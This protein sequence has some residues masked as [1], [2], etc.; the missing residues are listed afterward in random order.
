VTVTLRAYL[1]EP[2]RL[3]GLV[4][5]AMALAA[6][7]M[8]LYV[9][10]FR[11]GPLPTTLLE[12]FILVTAGLFALAVVRRAGRWPGRTPYE[13]PIVLF[14][15]GG[16]IGVFVAPDHRGGLGIFRAYLVEP[17]AIYYV[18]LAIFEST[19]QLLPLLLTWGIG[20]VLFCLVDLA[21][22]LQALANGSFEPGHAAAAFQINPNSIALYLEP[23]IGLAAGFLILGV[24]RQRLIALGLLAVVLP[25]EVATFSRGGLLALGILA[26]I[27]IITLQRLWLQAALIA[28]T[29]LAAYG[30]RHLPL[31]G[32]RIAQSLDPNSGTLFNRE[33]VWVA[34][35]HMLHDRPVFGAGLNAYQTVM[36]PYRAVDPNQVP[37]P[38]PHNFIFTAWTETGLLGLFAFV[39]ILAGLVIQ[40]WLWLRRATGV[41]RPLLWGAGAAF[42][43]IAVH[44][45]V[46]SPY[47]KNDL[48]LEF[49]LLAAI[50]VAAVRGVRAASH[51]PAAPARAASIA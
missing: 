43:M 2:A 41:D 29:G 37:E 17:I 15:L 26:F 27:A 21:T 22:F 35:A 9:V 49:W 34:T 7:A 23:I 4:R 46:D 11:F 24:G 32:T 14:L 51:A 50:Q 31:L 36:A 19:E 38:Y 8:P 12:I 10:R 33:R 5:G 6:A 42:A 25:A 20:T 3:L 30:V 16:A 47:W 18:A 28:G 13:I 40:P 39:W 44:G 45:L 1:D 48:S